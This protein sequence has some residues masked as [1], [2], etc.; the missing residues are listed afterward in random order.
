MTT[1]AD[2]G[3][4]KPGVRNADS[5]QELEEAK[6]DFPLEPANTLLLDFWLSELYK[7]KFCCFKPPVCGSSLQ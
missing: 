3:L 4:R 7:N 6:E 5:P 2:T 1:E